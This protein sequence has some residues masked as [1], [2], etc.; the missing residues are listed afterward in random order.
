MS[1]ERVCHVTQRL[2][3]CQQTRMSTDEAGRGYSSLFVWLK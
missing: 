3:V 2:V 1:R